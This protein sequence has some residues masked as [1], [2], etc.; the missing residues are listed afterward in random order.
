MRKPQRHYLFGRV[1]SAYLINIIPFQDAQPAIQLEQLSWV[2]NADFVKLGYSHYLFLGSGNIPQNAAMRPQHLAKRGGSVI[3][4]V[5]K[6]QGRLA[7]YEHLRRLPRV[8][9]T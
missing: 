1:A 2:V 7:A 4:V 9:Q 5:P 6:Q 3:C 8:N